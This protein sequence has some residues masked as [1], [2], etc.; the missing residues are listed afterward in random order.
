MHVITQG[1]H[2]EYCKMVLQKLDDRYAYNRRCDVCFDLFRVCG[3]FV[4]NLPIYL[5]L[6]QSP[7]SLSKV[8]FVPM[9]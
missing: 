5:L 8:P 7:A 6:F 1:G 4:G 9:R 2:Y 3:S